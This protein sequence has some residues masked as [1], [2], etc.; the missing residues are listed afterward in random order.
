MRKRE[1]K[2][3]ETLLK[4]IFR[5]TFFEIITAYTR[6]IIMPWYI[7]NQVKKMHATIDFQ[8]VIYSYLTN[9][10]GLM[11]AINN[12]NVVDCSL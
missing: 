4:R 6:D 7:F 3:R 10:C 12:R 9:E 1:T 2:T 8:L 11:K 5:A